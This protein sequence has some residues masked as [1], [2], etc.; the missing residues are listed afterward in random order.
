[1]TITGTSTPARMRAA[2]EPRKIRRGAANLLEPT[3][4]R[5]A[6]VPPQLFQRGLQRHAVGDKRFD[7]GRFRH[8]P[9]RNHEVLLGRGHLEPAHLACAVGF[10]EVLGRHQR[11][12]PDGQTGRTGQRDRERK[13]VVVPGPGRHRGRHCGHGVVGVIGV[14]AWRERHRDRRGVQQGTGDRSDGV[15]AEETVARAADHD[16]VRILLFG[17]TDERFGE[18]LAD[19]HGG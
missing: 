4:S 3:T 14:S 19:Q 15:A 7:L 17:E 13:R 9:R 18:R 16:E 2:V 6:V 11:Q 8:R 5:S 12:H 10:G 1:M